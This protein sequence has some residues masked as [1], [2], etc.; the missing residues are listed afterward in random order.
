MKRVIHVFVLDLSRK[1]SSLSP[2]SIILVLGFQGI[3][4]PLDIFG[5]MQYLP[6][7]SV[8][9][10]Q[11]A[12][13]FL[14]PG[15]SGLLSE[16]LSQNKTQGRGSGKEKERKKKALLNSYFAKSFGA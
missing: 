2:L 1:T 15:Q 7:M 8:P 10:R 14:I 3:S 4:F 11:E 13:E 6:M 16:T 5:W 9:Q 12:G